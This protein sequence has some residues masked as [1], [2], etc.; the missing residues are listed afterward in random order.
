MSPYSQGRLDG[1]REAAQSA[2]K[3][4]LRIERDLNIK[5]KE[6]RY[7]VGAAE[8]LR[9]FADEIEGKQSGKKEASGQ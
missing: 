7:A 2:R 1:L 9:A 5:S 8:A 4:A 6:H 3:A